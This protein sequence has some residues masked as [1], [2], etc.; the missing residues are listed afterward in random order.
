[1]NTKAETQETGKKKD[2]VGGEVLHI[3]KGEIERRKEGQEGKG[4]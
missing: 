2:R 1:M 3:G 4:S